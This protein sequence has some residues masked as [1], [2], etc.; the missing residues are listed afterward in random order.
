MAACGKKN[1]CAALIWIILLWFI[2]WPVAAFS[3]GIWILIQVRRVMVVS[4]NCHLYDHFSD[5][6]SMIGS[7]ILHDLLGCFGSTLFSPLDFV[8]FSLMI[9][10]PFE[11]IFPFL[12]QASTFLEK[13]ITWPR[14]TG[15]AIAEC[16]STCPT[17]W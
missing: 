14:D 10:Q 9:F 5:D 17:P 8:F 13:L 15:K 4:C 6:D 12:K 2:I 16:S 7:A 3:A 1:Y 11:A